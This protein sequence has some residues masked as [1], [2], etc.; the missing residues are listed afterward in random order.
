MNKIYAL[1]Y[2]HITHSLKVVSELARK[3]CKSVGYRKLPVFLLITSG[4]FYPGNK[5]ILI[6]D[7]N[8]SPIGLMD[9]AP[10][11]DFSSVNSGTG[12][13]T[14]ID[15]QYVVSVKHNGGY[16]NVSFGD[17]QNKYRLIDRNNQSER[18]F[19]VPR[20]DKLVTEVIPA[21]MTSSGMVNGAYLDNE[22]YSAFYRMGSG[23]QEIKDPSGN[24]IS[25]SDAYKYVTGGTTGYPASYDN[26][27]MIMSSTYKQLFDTSLQG[28]IG[29]HPR[30][31][32]SGSPLF[33]YDT[34][35]NKWV[36]IGVDSSGGV[37]GTNWAVINTDFVHK[38]I[39]E[40][41]DKAVRYLSS[42][43]PL[44]WRF[45]SQSGIG[46]LAQGENVYAM[47]GQNGDDLNTGKNLAFFGENGLVELQNSV[48]QG[49]GSLIFH[50]DY[51]VTT[52][53]GS[54]WTGA[55]IIVT[56]DASVN[57]Q[58][59]G[60]DG[61]NLHKLGEGKL[62]VRGIGINEGG[63]KVGD[64]TVILEQ[65]ADQNGHIQAFSSLNIASGR[66]IVVL[67][68]DKQVNPDHISWGYKGGMLDVNSNSLTF[69]QIKGT[70]YG[71]V[72]A[73]YGNDETSVR[74]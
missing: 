45:N 25:I 72:L 43:T 55:G 1:K 74:C 67:S 64:G 44:I 11:I 4:N 5:N 62:F 70:D 6:K 19:H 10:M 54:R 2:C 13:A 34:Y 12:V 73:N 3:A 47:H 38:S 32:D 31:G 16:Q 65:Q 15:P 57:W 7:R 60:V 68:N 33:A 37:G 48:T 29:T 14:L 23:T 8:A 66:P 35:L 21:S 36:L 18:D 41:S 59:N 51:T 40:D 52:S 30:S 26:G 49:A 28:I 46:S 17:G 50:N 69:H 22:R 42:E 61:D 24:I 9:K 39:L 27:K 63:L 53:N 71:A 56:K 20:L 58:V